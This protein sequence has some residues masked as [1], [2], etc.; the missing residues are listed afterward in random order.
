MVAPPQRFRETEAHNR[1]VGALDGGLAAV[2]DAP[3][4]LRDLVQ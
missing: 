2:P 3:Q 4:P 1:H